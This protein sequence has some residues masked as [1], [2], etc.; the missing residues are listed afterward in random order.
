MRVNLTD[1]ELFVCRMLGVMRRS[2]AMHK[3]KDQQMGEGDSWS[4]DIDGVVAEYCVAKL[5]NLCPDLTVSVRSGGADLI[6]RKGKT[7][8]VKSTRHVHGKLLATIK[9]AHDPCDMYVLVVVDNF[10]GTVMGWASK[11]DLFHDD[12]KQDLGYGIGY[13]ACVLLRCWSSN[14]QAICFVVWFRCFLYKRARFR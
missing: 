14:R 7:V 11:S 13:G 8:D 3:V 5:L 10:G 1:A 2:E 4:I 9:K 12:N 6:T